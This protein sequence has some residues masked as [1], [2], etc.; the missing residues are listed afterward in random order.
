[1][2]PFLQ[3]VLDEAGALNVFMDEKNMPLRHWE[4]L[5]CQQNDQAMETYV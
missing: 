2:S 3:Y 4:R 1:M 5:L